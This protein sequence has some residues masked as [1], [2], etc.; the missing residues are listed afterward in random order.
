MSLGRLPTIDRPSIAI[1]PAPT[2]NKPEIAR[3]SVLLPAP[4]GPISA[5]AWPAATSSEK[6][7]S[8]GKLP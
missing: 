3:A 6:F 7:S 4:L 1:S 5:S 8:T 2:F